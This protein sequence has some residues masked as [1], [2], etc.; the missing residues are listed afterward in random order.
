MLVVEGSTDEL[1]LGELCERGREQIFLGGDR[2]LVEQL[3][4]YLR[5]E[6]IDGCE[7]VF[8][9]DCDGRGKTV[10]LSSAA[11]LVVTEACDMEADL[12]AIGVVKRLV[13][14]YLPTDEAAA[15]LM[16]QGQA[17]GMVVSI[18][19]RAATAR[20]I[21]MKR[22]GWQLRLSDLP[23]IHLNN[24]EA[25]CPK[26]EDVL[27]I[28]AAELE[29]TEDQMREVTDELPAVRRDFASCCLGKDVLDSVYRLLVTQGTG[30]VRGWDRDYFYRAV[31]AALEP[32][33]ADSWEVGRRLKKWEETTGH[34]L[35]KRVHD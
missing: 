28:I 34:R 16:A 24:W 29:W 10:R 6:P 5:N 31:F 11:E 27:S 33:D 14:R 23:E 4:A 22:G 32:E 1:A 13:R 2:S 7:C 19:R 8:L 3:L 20:S 26:E 35:L 9:V 30:N 12:V 17:L 25:T 18:V 15:D 21:S